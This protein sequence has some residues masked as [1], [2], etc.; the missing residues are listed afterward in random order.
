MINI[1]PSKML[2]CKTLDKFSK[3]VLIGNNIDGFVNVNI[4]E[5]G[6]FEEVKFNLP[7]ILGNLRYEEIGRAHV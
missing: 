5:F 7:G 6:N 4:V 3:F 1:Y 2:Y